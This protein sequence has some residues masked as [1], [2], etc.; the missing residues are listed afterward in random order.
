MTESRYYLRRRYE[1]EKEEI[2]EGHRELWGNKC[3]YSPDAGGVSWVYGI[4]LYTLDMCS[5]S[6]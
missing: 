4:K 5:Y 2:T 6:M 3:V 1:W